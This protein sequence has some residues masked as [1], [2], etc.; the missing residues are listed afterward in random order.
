M[1]LLQ[2]VKLQNYWKAKAKDSG[3]S[4]RSSSQCYTAELG[5]GRSCCVFSDHE[6]IHSGA[7]RT[8]MIRKLLL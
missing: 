2:S 1:D 7:T 4:F 8:V 5:H 3:L 6:L